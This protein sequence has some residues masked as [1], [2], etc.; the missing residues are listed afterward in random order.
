MSDNDKKRER[1]INKFHALTRELKQLKVMIGNAKIEKSDCL[2]LITRYNKLYEAIFP[3]LQEW[4]KDT[5]TMECVSTAYENYKEACHRQNIKHLIFEIWIIH[6]LDF[7]PIQGQIEETIRLNS[8]RHSKEDE[9]SLLYPIKLNETKTEK[10]KDTFSVINNITNIGNITNSQ[11][12]IN[13]SGATNYSV[14]NTG[15]NFEQLKIL[16][17]AV[18]KE[19]ASLSHE[20]TETSEGVI[21]TI[22]TE[23]S[24]PNIRKS[25]L[26][27]ILSAIKAIKGTAEFGAAVTALIDFIKNL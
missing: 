7:L 8:I 13:S 24:K 22:E 25:F 18:R 9:I 19:M 27:H 12:N 6:N 3:K 5:E 1:V 20:D 10:G 11:L 16:I 23:L 4:Y 15:I 2:D 17:E 21:E 26:N 14:Q